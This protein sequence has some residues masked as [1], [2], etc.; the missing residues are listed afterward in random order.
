MFFLIGH[1]AEGNIQGVSGG[2]VLE[3][4]EETNPYELFVLVESDGIPNIRDQVVR[5]GQLVPRIKTLDEV[6]Q[7]ALQE[8]ILEVEIL[9]RRY[10]TRALIQDGIYLRKA[11]EGRRFLALSHTPNDL[12][13][14]PMIDAEVGITAG[15]AK[16]LAELWVTKAVE[17]DAALAAIEKTRLVTKWQIEN[18]TDV[19]TIKDALRSLSL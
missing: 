18:A 6:R 7:E 8:L 10:V 14:F 16:A 17:T 1:D 19:E 13:A 15:S 5:D 4:V 11:E 2:T 12:S 3:E 9:R